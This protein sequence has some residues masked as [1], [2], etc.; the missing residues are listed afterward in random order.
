MRRILALVVLALLALTPTLARAQGGQASGAQ[1]PGDQAK[2]EQAQSGQAGEALA[3][4]ASGN[5]DFDP[6][7]RDGLGCLRRSAC[8]RHHRGAAERHAVRQRRP[9]A[10]HQGRRRQ[11]QW[12]PQTGKPAPDVMASG[13][14][15]VRVNNAGAQRDR[16][17]AGAACNCSRPMRRHGCMPPRRCSNRMIRRRAADL[18][19]GAGEGNR[20][21][22]E[23]AHGAGA[24]RGVAVRDTMRRSRSGLPPSRRCA[25]A[26]IMES[27]ILLAGL[28]GSAAAGR[29]RG[30]CGRGLDRPRAATLEH[31]WKASITASAWVP[32]CCWR[33]PD[34]RSPSA[35]W[36]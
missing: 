23:A 15:L 19:Q 5:Y 20:P 21:G 29:R 11:V 18:G 25:R 26:A 32:C 24:G 33:P 34:W 36:A 22:G 3:L 12:T 13:L 8:R 2:S 14:K 1:A 16:C 31:R 7:G 6:P 30:A 10:V 27:R 28:I 17:G 35:S 9:R 4:L